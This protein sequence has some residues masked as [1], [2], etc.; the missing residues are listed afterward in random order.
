MQQCWSKVNK[1]KNSITYRLH[2]AI[3]FVMHEHKGN[4]LVPF[5]RLSELERRLYRFVCSLSLYPG[6]V[7]AELTQST[8]KEASMVK[9][10][11]SEPR[12]VIRVHRRIETRVIVALHPFRVRR[13]TIII[14]IRRDIGIVFEIIVLIDRSIDKPL[15]IAKQRDTNIGVVFSQDIQFCQRGI[16][17][18]RFLRIYYH[19]ILF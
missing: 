11:E 19:H 5:S 15:L 4:V 12:Q 1:S 14:E 16:E 2:C 17:C 3:V 6:K 8:N 18:W 10:S 9:S 7:F 13:H